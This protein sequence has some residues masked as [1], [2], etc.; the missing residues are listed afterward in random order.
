[1]QSWRPVLGRDK[2]DQE[3]RRVYRDHLDAVFG[4]FAY[5]LGRGPAE[6]LTATTFERVVKH[7]SRY[8]AARASERTWI[9]S[10]ARNTLIDHYRRQSHRQTTSLDEHPLIAASLQSS[11][12]PLARRLGEGA[13]L[14]LLSDLKPREQQILAMR[15]GADLSGA[16]IAKL[17]ELS[18]ANVHQIIS[19]TLKRMRTKAEVQAEAEPSQE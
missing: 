3:L 11:D 16:E 13:F 2:R 15:Y 10:I 12:D 9:L 4:F 6:D 7:W 19:R 18:E 1:V 14:E 5:S 17:V 8:D